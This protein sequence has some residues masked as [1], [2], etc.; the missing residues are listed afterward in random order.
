MNKNKGV[1]DTAVEF[2]VTRAVPKARDGA[3]G[4]LS[5]WLA[6]DGL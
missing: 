4:S 2:L 5:W 3:L 1:L 6:L